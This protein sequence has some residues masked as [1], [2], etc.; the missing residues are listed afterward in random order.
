MPENLTENRQWYASCAYIWAM[1]TTAA[2]LSKRIFKL[3][4]IL[5]IL[6]NYETSIVD[7]C[8]AYSLSKGAGGSNA[9][10]FLKNPW[11]V[12]T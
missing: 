3:L 11:H 4:I 7:N 6:L 1:E 2:R 9:L 8:F 12:L 5:A 10:A